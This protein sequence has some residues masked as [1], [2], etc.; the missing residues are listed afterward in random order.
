[1]GDNV[2][3]I[4]CKGSRL[5]PLDSL[6]IIQG[7][8]KDLS[9]ENYDKLRRRIEAKGFDAPLFVWGTKILDGTQRFRVLGKMIDGGWSLPGGMVPVCDIEA[10]SLDEAKRRLLGYVSQYGHLTDEGLFD[11]LQGLSDPGLGTLDL[12]GLD[13]DEFAKDYLSEETSQPN[14]DGTQTEKLPE[15][16]RVHILLSFPPR[17][18]DELQSILD[19][20]MLHPEVEY[21]QGEC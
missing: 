12:P 2:V 19:Q 14:N 7:G 17:L 1:M 15:H 13:I 20:I 18:K 21:E 11:F 5:V 16:H 8:L 3:Q 6:E 4:K 9:E 10:D